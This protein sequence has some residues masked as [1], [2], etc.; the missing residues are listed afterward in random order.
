MALHGLEKRAALHA[1]CK[2]GGDMSPSVYAPP[3][4]GPCKAGKH[5]DRNLS[6]RGMTPAEFCQVGVATATA[7][8][9]A[10]ATHKPVDFVARAPQGAGSQS[11]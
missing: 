4:D 5:A 7:T 8:A 1:D 11:A 6:Q 2:F 3:V 9:F 10:A